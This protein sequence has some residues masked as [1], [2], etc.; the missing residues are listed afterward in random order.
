MANFR[1]PDLQRLVGEGFS[2]LSF[3]ADCA[4]PAEIVARA[5]QATGSSDEYIY[6]QTRVACRVGDRHAELTCYLGMEDPGAADDEEGG[7]LDT[8]CHFHIQ[9]FSRHSESHA[10][11]SDNWTALYEAL[12]EAMPMLVGSVGLRFTIPAKDAVTAIKLPIPLGASETPGFSEVRGVRL[13][14]LDPTSDGEELYSVIIDHYRDVLAIDSRS[15]V[16]VAIDEGLL[17]TAVDR[18]IAIGSQAVPSLKAH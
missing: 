12:R 1:I 11:P 14:K 5:R 8:N 15:S 7:E 10:R 16:E 13:A 2:H 4:I 17:M 9:L 3:A 6:A 18:A